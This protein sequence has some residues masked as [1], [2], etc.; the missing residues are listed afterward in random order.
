MWTARALDGKAQV[1][2]IQGSEAA[3]GCTAYNDYRELL[4]ATR[5]T[6]S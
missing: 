3:G 5:S 1:D 4:R 2:D 6:R